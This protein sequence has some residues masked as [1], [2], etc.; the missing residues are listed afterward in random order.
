MDGLRV[1]D[2]VLSK[3]IFDDLT[4]VVVHV[5]TLRGSDVGDEYSVHDLRLCLPTLDARGILGISLNDI[6]IGI[7]REQG[8]HDWKGHAVERVDAQDA[9]VTNEGTSADAD[10]VGR[11]N[12][13]TTGAIPHDD[14]DVALAVS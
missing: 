4:D 12:D 13:A 6:T 1:L 5:G 3:P 14:S 10:D 9:V 7:H 8:I 11:T 2:T